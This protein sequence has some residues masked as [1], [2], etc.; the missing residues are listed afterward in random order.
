MIKETVMAQLYW[1]RT[2][3]EDTT[4]REN[5]A[6]V[7]TF[8]FSG[9]RMLVL[10]LFMQQKYFFPVVFNLLG[11]QPCW[12]ALSSEEQK[13]VG[14]WRNVHFCHINYA[15]FVHHIIHRLSNTKWPFFGY[16]CNSEVSNIEPTPQIDRRHA[17]SLSK[18]ENSFV[19]HFCW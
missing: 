3:S 14:L 5:V 2:W 19:F 4:W 15:D 18:M 7:P 13:Q 8:P 1:K 16:F 6:D 11:A 12:F 10:F 17:V 9:P